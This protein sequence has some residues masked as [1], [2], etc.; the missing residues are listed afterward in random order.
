MIQVSLPPLRS[1]QYSNSHLGVIGDS[2]NSADF[3]NAYTYFRSMYPKF[4]EEDIVDFEQKY[5]NSD[6]EKEDLIEF[7]ERY[8]VVLSSRID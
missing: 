4:T 7:Y 3:V 2:L 6:M 5:R 1:P 8:L